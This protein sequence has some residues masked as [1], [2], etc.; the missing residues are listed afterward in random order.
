MNQLNSQNSTQRARYDS[1][2]QVHSCY[3]LLSFSRKQ[4]VE[5]T[6]RFAPLESC[7]VE[8][9]MEPSGYLMFLNA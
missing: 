8:M 9:L 3:P 1:L 5:N 4:H 2:G 6:F 7:A